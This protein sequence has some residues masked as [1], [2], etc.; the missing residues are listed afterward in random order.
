MT[1]LRTLNIRFIRLRLIENKRYA[2]NPVNSGIRSQRSTRR[3][4]SWMHLPPGGLPAPIVSSLVSIFRR[5]ER[6]PTLPR[7]GNTPQ[8]EHTPPVP[9]VAV[10]QTNAGP[11]KVKKGML[12][13]LSA[14]LRDAA[15]Q[16]VYAVRTTRQHVAALLRSGYVSLRAYLRSLRLAS[17][18]PF[19]FKL[20]YCGLLMTDERCEWLSPYSKSRPHNR[21]SQARLR[22]PPRTTARTGAR[23]TV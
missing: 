21:D 16:V 7:S 20:G 5:R 12:P 4:A 3:R 11:I 22:R 18:Y 17:G 23:L 2:R 9:T 10:L 1:R 14:L 8:P 19:S 6:T 13:S 15:R